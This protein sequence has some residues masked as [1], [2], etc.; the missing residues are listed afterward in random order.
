MRSALLVLAFALVAV[1]AHAQSNDSRW[2][3][4]FGCWTLAVENQRDGGPQDADTRRPTPPAATREGAPRVCVTRTTSGAR[5][6][7]TVAAQVA[8]D[9]TIVADGAPHP[10]SDTECTGTQTS[11]WSKN[12]L[13][14]FSS[15]EVRCQGDPAPRRVSGLSLIAPNG[16][17][18]DIQTVVAGDRETIRV[19]RYEREA[20]SPGF[21]FVRPSVAASRLT[22]DEVAEAS[23]KVSPGALE[24][25]LVEMNAGFNLTAKGLLQ[26]DS[27]GVP[28]RIIDLLVA[29][30][31]PEKFVVQKSTPDGASFPYY[32]DPFALGW[33]Y[34]YG[35]PYY[36]SDFY[37]SPYFYEPFGWRGYSALGSG[38]ILVP[39]EPGGGGSDGPA[40]S[41]SGRVV[42]GQGYTRVIPRESPTGSAF[43]TASTAGTT[44]SGSSSPPPASGS[45]ASSGSSSGSSGSS[46]GG[47]SASP[48]GGY[49]SGSG[50][51][52][53]GRTAVPR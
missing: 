23:G 19:K 36:A 32:R 24:A 38:I 11:E 1:P 40:R 47:G 51:S 26:L 28:T 13:R 34:G 12:G 4:W 18:I 6:E 31:Y 25:A 50:S 43:P 2:E 44:A 48:T 27:A 22:L 15:A 45:T 52:D 8:I 41:G 29:L 16:N 30:S 10:V 20:A 5:F 35:Y 49:S 53:S 14:L 42:N 3:P 33:G 39:V 9:Q 37:G 21:G 46:S 7:T 17:W